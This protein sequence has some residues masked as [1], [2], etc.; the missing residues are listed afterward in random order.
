MVVKGESAS[1]S[2]HPPADTASK[3]KPKKKN[4][5]Q[6]PPGQPATQV[7]AA[8]NTFD[9]LSSSVQADG[10]ISDW[11]DLAAD[12]EGTGSEQPQAPLTSGGSP[13]Q[14]EWPCLR[15]TFLNLATHSSCE[16]CASPRP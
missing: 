10:E 3:D 6:S 16:M 7:W 2:A 4:T 9:V 5:K 1:S 13:S 12:N 11:E 15:C 8:P 14:G